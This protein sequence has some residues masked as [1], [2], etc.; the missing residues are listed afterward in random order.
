MNAHA[1]ITRI[2]QV[3]GTTRVIYAQDA[4]HARR[5]RRILRTDPAMIDY[6]QGVD[7]IVI[8]VCEVRS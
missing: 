1:E 5:A 8:R 7:G 2:V 3:D 4:D 6:L